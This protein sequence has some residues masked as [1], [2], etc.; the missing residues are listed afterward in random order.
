MAMANHR[1]GGRIIIGVVEEKKELKLVGASLDDCRTWVHDDIAAF[2]SRHA[3]PTI[4][5]EQ[6]TVYLDNEGCVVLTVKQFDVTPIIC[7]K[8]YQAEGK[9]VLRD[10]ACYVRSQGKPESVEVKGYEDMRT[11]LDMAIDMGVERFVERLRRAGLLPKSQ[12]VSAQSDK[13]DEELKKWL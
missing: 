13:Y 3:D 2:L 11:L 8:T 9:D 1:G 12:E 10:G 6:E 4:R 5:F 7:C